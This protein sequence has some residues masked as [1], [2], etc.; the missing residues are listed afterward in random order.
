MKNLLE[1]FAIF[2]VAILSMGIIYLI[3][4]YNS[5]DDKNFIDPL[6][7]TAYEMPTEAELEEDDLDLDDDDE[8]LDL[9][10]DED[11]EDEE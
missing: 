8:D 1:S 3:I 11:L 10:D 6:D 5:I 7:K 2:L 4:E 9:E